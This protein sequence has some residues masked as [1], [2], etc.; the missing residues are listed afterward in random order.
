MHG[1]INVNGA[2]VRAGGRLDHSRKLITDPVNGSASK[3]LSYGTAMSC[4]LSL[5]VGDVVTFTVI[6]DDAVSH[7]LLT[8]GGY[9]WFEVEKLA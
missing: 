1:L 3:F 8:N 4:M 7:N 6:H 2:V 5:K 9:S